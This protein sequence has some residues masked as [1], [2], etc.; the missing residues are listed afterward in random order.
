MPASRYAHLQL[1]KPTTRQPEVE[2]KK[3]V[4]RPKGKASNPDYEPT[5]ILLRR[6]NKRRFQIRCIEEGKDMSE[7]VDR[8]IEEY[9]SKAEQI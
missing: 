1:Q 8:L 4:G 6:V 9:I 2:E 3:K 7:I 5:T